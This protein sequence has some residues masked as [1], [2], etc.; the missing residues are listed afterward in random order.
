LD[1]SIDRV[2]EQPEYNWRRPRAARPRE[3]S[4]NWFVRQTVALMDATGRGLRSAAQWVD[5]FV[6]WLGGRL[7]DRL[8]EVK[9]APNARA[10]AVPLR[11]VIIALLVALAGVAVYSV[12]KLALR[13]KAEP[14]PPA[15]ETPPVAIDLAAG[16]LE[17]D[18]QPFD[19]WLELARKSMDSG[20]PRLA[21]RALYLAG[22]AWLASG[23]LITLNRAKSDRDYVRELS[24]RVRRQPEIVA[25]FQANLL[26][27]ERG[28]YGMYD[29]QH[30]DIS[31]A[32][33]NLARLRLIE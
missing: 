26:L 29:V 31:A 2:L 21:L 3:P 28:W 4:S 33:E 1:R 13:R 30:T 18:T 10:P 32:Q 11:V 14:P 25:A 9:E 20:Q 8:P 17:A 22:L 19:A 15:V 27:F 7:G 12:W 16:D 6:E 23:S 5:G 24:R